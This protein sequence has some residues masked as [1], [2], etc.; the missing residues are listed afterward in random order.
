MELDW[1]PQMG[2]QARVVKRCDFLNLKVSFFEYFGK[3]LSKIFNSI[4]SNGQG[5]SDWPK[6]NC[7]CLL[8]DNKRY[9]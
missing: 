8:T 9:C 5:T 3:K 7:E 2:L 1:N 4:A 6:E